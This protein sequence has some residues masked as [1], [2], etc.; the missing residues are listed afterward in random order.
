M[1][2][3]HGSF[4]LIAVKKPDLPLLPKSSEL[5]PPSTSKIERAIHPAADKAFM[6]DM[7]ETTEKSCWGITLWAVIVVLGLGVVTSIVT[8]NATNSDVVVASSISR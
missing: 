5:I 1:Q 6:G 3:P 7:H 4:V 2:K 8:G